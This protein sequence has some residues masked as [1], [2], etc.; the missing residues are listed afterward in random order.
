MCTIVHA[1]S[2]AVTAHWASSSLITSEARTT[3]TTSLD[4][5][6]KNWS[7]SY[8]FMW[9]VNIK[10]KP[11]ALQSA[12][13]EKV[14][15]KRKDGG[16]KRDKP[17]TQHIRVVSLSIVC[18]GCTYPGYNSWL[19]YLSANQEMKRRKVGTAATWLLPTVCVLF[20]LPG[21]LWQ[22]RRRRQS[23][24]CRA[25]LNLCDVM[26]DDGQFSVDFLLLCLFQLKTVHAPCRVA[27]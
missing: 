17:P 6:R 3:T 21:D 20:V 1:Y 26:E 27:L 24:T 5:G 14:D 22:S 9:G 13:N 10:K 8:G 2:S 16:K 18:F 23:S 12:V 11:V 7:A 4:G 25:S 19:I 15:N